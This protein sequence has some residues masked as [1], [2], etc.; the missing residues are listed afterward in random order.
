M[1]ERVRNLI[2]NEVGR[3]KYDNLMEKLKRKLAKTRKQIK[4]KYSNKT[5]RDNETY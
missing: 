2:R 3:R 5:K 1:K 4:E